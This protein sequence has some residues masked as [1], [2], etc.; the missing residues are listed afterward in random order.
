ME[1]VLTVGS[2]AFSPLV[3]AFLSKPTFDALRI[4]R[5]THLT[6]Q[7]GTSDLP[8][9]WALGDQSYG[10]IK[11]SIYRFLPDLEQSVASADLVVSHAGTRP[12]FLVPLELRRL[13]P[14][15]PTQEPAPSSPSFA[16]ET[17]S[18][19]AGSSSSPTRL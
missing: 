10:S 1:C 9:P 14:L 13:T 18:T 8:A 17:P 11:V 7:I 3:S 16:R 2:T 15:D 19:T 4:L 6:V 12:S 5:A